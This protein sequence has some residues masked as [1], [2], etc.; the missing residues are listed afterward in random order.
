MTQ[1]PFK[2]HS[3]SVNY[4]NMIILYRLG[5]EFIVKA[6]MLLEDD[7]L[8][9]VAVRLEL[10]ATNKDEEYMFGCLAEICRC[11]KGD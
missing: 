6:T 9:A 2:S 11:A 8:E 3:A 1:L 7:E 4:E 10:A 5:L